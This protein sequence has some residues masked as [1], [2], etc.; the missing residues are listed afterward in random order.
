MSMAPSRKPSRKAAQHPENPDHGGRIGTPAEALEAALAVM[1]RTE[2]QT[3]ER[4]RAHFLHGMSLPEI[5]ARDGVRV[6]GV[7]NAV[8]R[9]RAK[10]AQLASPMP[11]RESL[12]RSAGLVR[13]RAEDVERALRSMPRTEEQT[14]ERMRAHFVHG[15]GLTEIAE[16][17]GIRVESVANAARRVREVLEEQA[18]PWQYVGVN[19]TLPV[20]LA[21]EL[22][23]LSEQLGRIK[24]RSDADAAL[25]PVLAAVIR[26]RK[27][28]EQTNR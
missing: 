10:L 18:S 15:K 6:E 1:H 8:R 25:E 3:K 12:S 5:A 27:H 13:A 19:L 14:K 24:R 17:D 4:M 11:E 20:L 23:A 7:A 28:T 9:V 26:A 21:Q 16:Q 2:E 22:Q